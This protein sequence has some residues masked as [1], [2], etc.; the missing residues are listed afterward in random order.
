MEGRFAV[1]KGVL[2]SFDLARA[3]QPT[4]SQATGRTLF[5]ELSGAGVY[6]KGAVQLR[7]MK[8]TAGLLSANGSMDIDATGRVSGRVNADLG[9]QRGSI[10]LAGTARDPKISR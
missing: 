3:L 4:A 1:S 10:A 2:G 8:L 7:D 6:S 5:S 9:Q